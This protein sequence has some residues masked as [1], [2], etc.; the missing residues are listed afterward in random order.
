M[1]TEKTKQKVGKVYFYQTAQNPITH[2]PV[3]RDAFLARLDEGKKCRKFFT[4]LTE[5]A[6]E[7]GLTLIHV[8]EEGHYLFKEGNFVEYPM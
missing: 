7:Q 8:F 5:R 6:R 3:K 2:S 1:M 4:Q